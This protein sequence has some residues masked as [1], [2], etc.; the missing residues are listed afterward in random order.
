MRLLLLGFGN[1]GRRLAEIL[2]DRA[3]SPGL[4]DLDGP[5]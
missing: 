3:S 4:A 1:V 5:G 2:V